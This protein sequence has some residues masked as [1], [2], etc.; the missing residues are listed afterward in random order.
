[1]NNEYVLAMYDVRGKQDYI[2][3]GRKMKEI[4]GASLIISDIY[5]DYLLDEGDIYS[6]NANVNNAN[7]IEIFSWDKFDARMKD[8]N[9][10]YVGEVIY[11]GG[12][13]FLVLYKNLNIY[14]Q[15]TH[16]FT[17][18]VLKNTYSLRVIGT[19]IEN[20]H[21]DDYEAD[22]TRLYREHRKT[23]NTIQTLPLYGSLPISE[24]NPINSM[25]IL[26]KGRRY[27]L[28][29]TALT[30]EQLAKYEK[31]A[32]SVSLVSSNGTDNL[33]PDTGDSSYIAII[34]IDGN[35]IGGK[36]QECTRGLNSYDDCIFALR[37]LSFS[38]QKE[39][40]DDKIRIID[41]ELSDGKVSNRANRRL[42]LGAG[43]EINLVVPAKDAFRVVKKYL[44]SLDANS[45]YSACAGIAIMRSHMP[46]SD[47]YRIAEQCC[48]SGKHMMRK[49]GFENTSFLDFH[50]CQ[51][52]IGISLEQIRK[53]EQTEDI[54]RPWLIVDPKSE[55]D[56]ENHDNITTMEEID[57][58]VSFIQFIGSINAK[59]LL[60]AS[61]EGE[62]ALEMELS[63][64]KGF[65]GSN[66]VDIESEKLWNYIDNMDPNKKR[67]LIYD[68]MV[69]YDFWFAGAEEI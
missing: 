33:M 46:Y 64:V 37:K 56:S 13:N 68:V 36:V 66:S 7:E 62:N 19:C 16:R 21:P 24:L 27:G 30:G 15:I 9:S 67:K 41:A 28:N 35:G 40:V 8:E 53:D 14:K 17:L 57:L 20:L 54:S 49:L 23:E 51:G 42:V 39:C 31:Q 61:R 32:A 26:Y 59:R 11:D 52:A 45:G 22:R 3:R 38:I 69:M 47:A 34:Y 29:A 65:G 43:D 58:V 5:K 4:V 44:N 60:E 63:R 48:E 1:M 2:F 18:K 55:C 12:G 6:Y 50:I 10:P 25:P